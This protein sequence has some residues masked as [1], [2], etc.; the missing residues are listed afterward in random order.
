MRAM[1]KFVGA[2]LA[3]LALLAVAMPAVAQKTFTLGATASIQPGASRQVVITYKNNDTGN[4]SFNSVRI[5]GTSGV[6]ITAATTS[7]N[8]RGTFSAFGSNTLTITDL[9]PTKTGDTLTV[10]LTVTASAGN[11]AA[12]SISWTGSAWTGSPSSPSNVFTQT[13]ANPTTSVSAGTCSVTFGPQPANALRGQVVSDT[14]F[15]PTAAKARINVVVNGSPAANGTQV[16]VTSSCTAGALTPSTTFSGTTTAGSLELGTLKSDAVASGCTLTATVPSLPAVTPAT[17][18]AF[19][20]VEP[21]VE[22]TGLP[23]SFVTGVAVTVGA[24]LRGPGGTPV[25]QSGSGLLTVTGA[26]TPPSITQSGTNGVVTFG[27]VTGTTVG[28][29]CSL[30]AKLTFN[31]VEYTSNVFG[32]Y[33]VFA[34]GSLACGDPLPLELSQLP[35]PP[36]PGN[37]YFANLASGVTNV[38]Q[39]GFA[40]GYRAA[41]D[42]ESDCPQLVNY[43]FTNNLKGGATTTDGYG[44]TLPKNAVSFV[45]DTTALPDGVFVYTVTFAEDYVNPLTGLPK[46]G[47]KFC[48]QTIVAGNPVPTDCTSTGGNLFPLLTCEG[49]VTGVPLKAGSIPGTDPACIVRRSWVTVPLSNCPTWTGSGLPPACVR[50]TTTILDAKDPPVIWE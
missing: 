15:N 4:S 11:C 17:S 12:G 18:S 2:W 9:S 3:A 10:T 23:K 39:A 46:N 25:P 45:W 34:S 36:V 1:Q 32:P 40:A 42:K 43:T 28:G 24:E 30:T 38:D 47:E 37:G 48:K 33:R 5:T 13:N 49:D 21:T 31:G 44:N 16:N 20:V 6:V 22:I 35:Y 7:S 50:V 26:C 8:R 27:A 14:N 41:N 19:N 29:T